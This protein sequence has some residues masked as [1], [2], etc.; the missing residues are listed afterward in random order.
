MYTPLVSIIVPIYK[1]EPYLR[2]CLDSIVNQTYANL[3]IILVDDGSPDGCPQICDEYA[4]ND[5]RIIVVHKKNGG[6]SDAR[7]VG[8]DI[9]KGDYI[10]FVDSDD[11]V[12]HNF[13][14]SLIEPTKK[15]SYDF[16]IADHLS[17]NEQKGS[18]HLSCNEGP[19]QD[20]LTIIRSYCSLQYPPSAWAKIYRS[21]FLKS[22]Q[23][24][25]QKGLLFEDQLW[26]CMLASSA[27]KIFI[28]HKQVYHYTIR[29]DSIMQ[30]ND[31]DFSKRLSSWCFILSTE[32]EIL[33]AYKIKLNKLYS[34]FFLNKII[35]ILKISNGQKQLFKKTFRAIKKTIKKNPAIFWLKQTN[36]LEKIFFSLLSISPPFF[37]EEAMFFYLRYQKCMNP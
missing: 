4:S 16:I 37:T 1:V 12:D 26:S 25:F 2:R 5:N 31:I 11:Y 7:N 13:I 27:E 10:S 30:C 29:T 22:N 14:E 15:D 33:S 17:S 21:S 36:G 19:I 32:L 23:F 24:R 20:N 6:L 18:T 34:L 3:E 8:L 28:I 9:C 35:E